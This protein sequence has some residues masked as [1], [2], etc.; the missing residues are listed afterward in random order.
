MVKKNGVINISEISL[1]ALKEGESCI[2]NGHKSTGIMAK[3]L[4]ELGFM[5]GTRVTCLLKSFAGDPTAY[6]VK[7][8][9]IALRREDAEKI[10]VNL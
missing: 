10:K 9:V 8:A 4:K 2:I 6:L 7:G 5:S 1:S 3:R